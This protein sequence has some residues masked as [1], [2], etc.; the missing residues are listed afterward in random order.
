MLELKRERERE[1]ERQREGGSFSKCIYMYI[2]HVPAD[3][4]PALPSFPSLYVT[5]SFQCQPHWQERFYAPP[6]NS[7]MLPSTE[8][9]RVSKNERLK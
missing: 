6:P 1:R 9:E 2:V 5:I 4:N 7:C 3:S 8:N